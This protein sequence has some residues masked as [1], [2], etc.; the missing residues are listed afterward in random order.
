[1][2]H[3]STLLLIGLA[4]LSTTAHAA[5]A[6]AAACSPVV[7]GAW[8]RMTP[9]MPIGAGYFTI[10]N[11]CG[12]PITLTGAS[13]A[14][15][16]DVT[17]HETRLENG[18]SRMLPLAAQTIA[19]GRR[20]EFRPGGRHLMLAMPRAGSAV[21]TTHLR[22]ELRLADGRVMPVDFELRRAAP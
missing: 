6:N 12:A 21:P 7:R 8:V 1:M 5:P 20:I 2:R 10:E 11:P 22:I 15:F 4:A 9:V 18:I 13:S 17:M 14:R 19:P 3:V 16:S